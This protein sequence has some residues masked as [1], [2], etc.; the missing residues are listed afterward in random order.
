MMPGTP[1]I[2][3]DLDGTLCD[4]RHR[5]HLAQQA[6]WEEFH[7]ALDRDE[8]YQDVATIVKA[9]SAKCNVVLCTGRN[10]THRHATEWWLADQGLAVHIEDI[11]MRPDDD[12]SPD[13][14][15]K[16]QMLMAWLEANDA[17]PDE[18]LMVIDDR[19]KVVDAWR[20]AGFHCW[21][22][23]PGGY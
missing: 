19:D 20:E 14:T 17:H 1:V 6:R 13:H 16:P 15:L 18:V 7:S 8:P 5:D 2:V 9:I 3:V 10:E 21:Q 4:S 11:I 12:F 22:V 23:R